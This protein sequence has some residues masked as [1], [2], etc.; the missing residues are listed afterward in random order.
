MLNV[1][2]AYDHPAFDSAIDEL[3]D[4]KIRLSCLCLKLFDCHSRSIL[5]FP[6]QNDRG[7]VVG[8]AELCNKIHFPY[9]NKYDEEIAQAFS[10]F[11][12][13]S[14]INVG[15]VHFY[16]IHTMLLLCVIGQGMIPLQQSY[17]PLISMVPKIVRVA[18]PFT[19]SDV[20]TKPIPSK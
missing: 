16:F 4:F 20:S 17:L 11:C 3:T 8:V 15:S 1:G 7:K 2:H 14:I 12:N 9:F 6:I 18:T 13:I 5:C 10:V 19:R